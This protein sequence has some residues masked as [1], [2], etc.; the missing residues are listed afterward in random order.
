MMGI[1]QNLD[2]L[3]DLSEQ[4]QGQEGNSREYS[5]IN[6][7]LHDLNEKG[8]SKLSE[9]ENLKKL[10]EQ[11]KVAFKL[12]EDECKALRNFAK[13]LLEIFNAEPTVQSLKSGRNLQNLLQ[14]LK[15]FTD[16]YEIKLDHAFTEFVRSNYGGGGP[17]D[18][19]LSAGK[20]PNNAKILSTFRGEYEGFLNITQTRSITVEVL[21]QIEKSGAVLIK[22]YD[23]LDF[24]VPSEV[25]KFFD[26]IERGGANLNDLTNTVR[27]Y[28]NENNIAPEFKII[29]NRNLSDL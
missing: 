26:A 11:K 20:T 29:K 17:K 5:E 9:H 27:E 2:D 24:E 18:L 28:L 19:E 16:A 7:V 6:A 14:A 21:D 10:Y 25:K 23:K 12:P 1:Q 15:K 4:V 22:L 8:L 3:I 13:N